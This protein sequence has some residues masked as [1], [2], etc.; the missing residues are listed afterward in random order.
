[1]TSFFSLATIGGKSLALLEQLGYGGVFFLSFL[2]RATISLIPSEVLLPLY[3]FLIGKG[4]FSLMP[5]FLII[6]VGALL[7]EVVLYWIFAFGG[8]PF[9]EKY[10]KYFLV[11]KHDLGHL[12]RL[13]EKHGV[14]LIFWGRFIPVARSIVAIPAGIAR[15]GFKR[16]VFYSFF[17]MMP[18]NFFLIFLGQ[19]TGENFS[20]FSPYFNITEKAALLILALLVIWYIYRHLKNRHLTH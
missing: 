9:L 10:G 12:D 17:G 20:A 3:G 19:K 7:G 4:I 18:Y 5:V 2:D 14:A 15:Q 16:F 6:S 13:V 11:S 1:M 8:R